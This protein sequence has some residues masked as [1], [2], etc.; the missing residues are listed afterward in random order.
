MVPRG[1]SLFLAASD[2]GPSTKGRRKENQKLTSSGLPPDRTGFHEIPRPGDARKSPWTSPTSPPSL[3]GNEQPPSGNPGVTQGDPIPSI[4]DHSW[5]AGTGQPACRHWL[6]GHSQPDLLTLQ[7]YL[8]RAGPRLKS[9]LGHEWHYR[10]TSY[11]YVL[12]YPPTICSQVITNFSI[13]GVPFCKSFHS[14][15]ADIQAIT[16]YQ[17]YP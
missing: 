1:R 17:I 5:V 15:R 12:S 14:F 7:G 2:D 6:G 4:S 13:E 9:Q 3:H 10:G 16:G 8:P 11:H